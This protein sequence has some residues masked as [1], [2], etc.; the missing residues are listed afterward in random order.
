[1]KCHVAIS[2]LAAAPIRA[3]H[4]HRDRCTNDAHGISFASG[5]QRGLGA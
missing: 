4:E 3:E 2:D 5:D 1:M